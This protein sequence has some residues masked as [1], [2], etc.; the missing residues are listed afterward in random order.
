MRQVFILGVLLGV[1]GIANAGTL[2]LGWTVDLSNDALC[3]D[4]K[5][6]AVVTD[7]AGKVTNNCKITGIEIQQKMTGV[8]GWSVIKGVG[9]T[10]NSFTVENVPVGE[11]R[12]YRFRANGGGAYS[13]PSEEFCSSP[14][15]GLS[16]NTIMK[17][18]IVITV[19][20]PSQ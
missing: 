18:T 14:M 19:T 13:K 10:V 16:P 5:T 2:V 20:G 9:P 17:A 4:G 11:V 1:C 6:K 3:E 8:D 12:C 15:P 7:A